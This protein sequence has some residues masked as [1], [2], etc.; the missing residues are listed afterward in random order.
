LPFTLAALSK[1]PGKL[2]I[3][4]FFA[5]QLLIRQRLGVDA[6]EFLNICSVA[7]QSHRTTNA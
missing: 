3:I 4:E 1:L 2:R 5:S 7:G 6:V